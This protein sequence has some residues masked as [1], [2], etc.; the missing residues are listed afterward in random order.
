MQQL[1]D[2]EIHAITV[3]ELW[4][5]DLT[6]CE[7]D[8]LVSIVHELSYETLLCV[9]ADQKQPSI[10]QTLA[11]AVSKAMHEELKEDLAAVDSQFFTEQNVKVA[12]DEILAIMK[13]LCM[14]KKIYIYGIAQTSEEKDEVIDEARQIL[15]VEDVIASILLVDDL[16]IQKN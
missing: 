14:K 16:R 3:E 10:H 9:L 13:N 2:Q 15:D 11:R 4:Y 8:V 5:Q 12:Q 6:L 1:S 7:L